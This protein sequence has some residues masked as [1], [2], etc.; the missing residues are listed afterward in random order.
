M[1]KRLAVVELFRETWAPCKGSFGP[2]FKER[3]KPAMQTGLERIAEKA[4]KEAKL[5]FTSLTHHL[6]KELIW[7]SLCHIPKSQLLGWMAERG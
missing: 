5:V 3:N 2:L 1:G 7:E 6:T 4:R